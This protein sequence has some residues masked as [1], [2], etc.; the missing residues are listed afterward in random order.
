MG[1]RTRNIYF[2]ADWHIGHENVLRLDKRPFADLETMNEGLIRRFNACVQENDVFYLN[3][4][5]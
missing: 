4:D 2:S 3:G 1:R 5:M